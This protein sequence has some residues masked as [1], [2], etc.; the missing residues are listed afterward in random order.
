M[1]SRIRNVFSKVL[2]LFAGRMN[3]HR[4]KGPR[5]GATANEDCLAGSGGFLPFRRFLVASAAEL[6]V[7]IDRL[8]EVGKLQ[9]RVP[10]TGKTAPDS[11]YRDRR[12][13]LSCFDP[14][15]D[16]SHHPEPARKSRCRTECRENKRRQQECLHETIST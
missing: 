3:H 7:A 9:G 2:R 8:A 5:P 4:F 13:V 6:D 11:D 14:I 12:L 10:G 1:T 15:D 16:D